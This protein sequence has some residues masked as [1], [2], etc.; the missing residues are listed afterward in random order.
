M[1]TIFIGR[2]KEIQAIRKLLTGT[3]NRVAILLG[4][5]GIGKT[6]F[7]QEINQ[8]AENEIFKLMWWDFDEYIQKDRPELYIKNK[9]L[10][11]AELTEKIS[12][13]HE[14]SFMEIS[15]RIN[16]NPKRKLLLF[17][18]LEKLNDPRI[19]SGLFELFSK[20]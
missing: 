16:N 7:L 13:P 14:I 20:D 9:F 12:N 10:D 18:T 19:K 1:K 15:K 3:K 2:Q 17:D 6:R 5:G 11:A 4:D 8:I